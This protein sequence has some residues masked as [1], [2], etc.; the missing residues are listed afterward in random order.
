[1][2]GGGAFLVGVSSGVSAFVEIPFMRSAPSLAE[3]LRLRGVFA[4]GAV[5]Y[6]VASAAWALVSDAVAV[7]AIRIAIG[8]GFGLVYP[9]LVV[10]TG[11]LVPAHARNSGQ[12][13]MS[14]C[15]FG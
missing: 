3:R 4:L 5:V 10:I 2:G 13:L 15:S 12:A 8:V 6:V 11:R 1:S 14:I 9:A 7:T